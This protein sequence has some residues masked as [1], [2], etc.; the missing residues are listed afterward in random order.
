MNLGFKYSTS[1][2]FAFHYT[3][4]CKTALAGNYFSIHSI[5]LLQLLE[6]ISLKLFSKSISALRMLLRKCIR[7]VNNRSCLFN[8]LLSTDKTTD[9]TPSTPPLSAPGQPIATA[10]SDQRKEGKFVKSSKSLESVYRCDDVIKNQVWVAENQILY[11][12]VAFILNP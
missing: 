7:S 2:Q 8:R 1:Y 12:V 11:S 6:I 3:R 10:L 9:G 5:S 4:V